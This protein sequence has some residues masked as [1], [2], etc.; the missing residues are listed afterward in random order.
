LDGTNDDRTQSTAAQNKLVSGAG[1]LFNQVR[2]DT[3][4][5]SEKLVA[6]QKKLFLQSIYPKKYC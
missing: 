5:N 2:V 4:N 6:S 3:K 1:L